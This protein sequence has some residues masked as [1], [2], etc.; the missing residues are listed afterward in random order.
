MYTRNLYLILLVACL[1]ALYAG[2]GRGN[3]TPGASARQYNSPHHG[4]GPN[5]N[6]QSPPTVSSPEVV[7]CGNQNAYGYE[8]SAVNIEN[9]RP[10]KLNEFAHVSKN[11]TLNIF[12]LHSSGELIAAAPGH[13]F[14]SPNVYFL[15]NTGAVQRCINLNDLLG[16]PSEQGRWTARALDWHP[17][18]R[19]LL[20]SIT[21][22]SP[23]VGLKENSRLCLYDYDTNS[24]RLLG[25]DYPEGCYDRAGVFSPDGELI[26]HL[27]GAEIFVADD[28]LENGRMISK[29]L[30]TM[31]ENPLL[32][33]S[34]PTLKY[35]LAWSPNGKYL[36]CFDD[37]G[38]YLLTPEGALAGKIPGLDFGACWTRE[39]RI[40]G[41][42]SGFSIGAASLYLIDPQT[43]SKRPITEAYT[44]EQLSCGRLIAAKGG[45]GR[46][47]V[48]SDPPQQRIYLNGKY[49]GDTTP[50]DFTLE[51]GP[52]LVKSQDYAGRFTDEASV[53]IRAD[54]AQ[55]ITL[56]S[57]LDRR[58]APAQKKEI[59]PADSSE[60][61]A[62]SL[63]EEVS[64]GF[65]RGIA[66][67]EQKK[68]QNPPTK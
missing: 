61:Q 39:N 57:E 36:L 24:A 11:D 54:E 12:A 63:D 35:F 56:L 23:Q 40:V 4:P 64:G 9:G 7:I 67:I 65:K 20:I 25:Q 47:T 31:G 10:R 37:S 14:F 29:K 8:V 30:V 55:N 21:A 19:K 34:L 46:L 5:R 68:R 62:G 53:T 59:S 44:A 48:S 15:D 28:N 58:A 22:F 60:S 66:A 38:G 2:C 52:Y 3:R 42:I 27:H 13:R 45:S 49:T 1:A 43:G 16:A 50:C 26:A 18:E 17:R 51:A 32:G 41:G 33:R 6:L